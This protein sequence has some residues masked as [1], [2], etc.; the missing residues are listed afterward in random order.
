MGS[1]RS[2]DA[3]NMNGLAPL[4]RALNTTPNTFLQLSL[5]FQELPVCKSRWIGSLRSRDQFAIWM[6]SLRSRDQF[7]KWMG[8]LRSRDQFGIWMDS[9]YLRSVRVISSQYGWARSARV[10]G[11]VRHIDHILPQQLHHP[12]TKTLLHHN[13]A[14]PCFTCAHFRAPRCRKCPKS[15]FC[16]FLD[17]WPRRFRDF[18]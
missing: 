2:C 17:A 18:S 16:R 4:A 1:L 5:S 3:R 9:L 7:A 10:C 12:I 6:G 14:T 8:S 15:L 11:P 13:F